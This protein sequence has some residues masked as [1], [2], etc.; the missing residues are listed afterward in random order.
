MTSMPTDGL[1]AARHFLKQPLIYDLHIRLR[2]STEM[3][4]VEEHEINPT[5]GQCDWQLLFNK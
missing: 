1:N 3:P 2:S 4:T 5:E